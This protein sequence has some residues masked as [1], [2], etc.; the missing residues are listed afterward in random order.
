MTL[1]DV[2]HQPCLTPVTWS[3]VNIAE[4]LPGVPSPLGW[5][6]WHMRIGK[7]L[8]AI[9]ILRQKVRAELGAGLQ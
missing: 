5:T 2:L 8:V 7:Q 3:R 6:F 9:D 4:A 1:T